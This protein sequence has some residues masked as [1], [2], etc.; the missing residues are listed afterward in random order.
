M[1]AK[2]SV[3]ELEARLSIARD[4]LADTRLF[5]P[6]SGVVTSRIPDPHEMVAQGSPVMTLDD[7]SRIEI[8]VDVPETHIGRFL[9]APKAE[10]HYSA[11]F[12]TRKDKVFNAVL[13]EYSSRADQA[14]GTYRFVFTVTPAP[15]DL[16]FAGM[17][18]QVRLSA[19]SEKSNDG[20]PVV[21]V[22]LESLLGVAGNSAHVFIVDPKSGTLSRRAVTFETLA[23]G[24]QVK[25]TDGLLEDDLVVKQG[26]AFVRQGQ[27]VEYRM[28]QEK[29]QV[30]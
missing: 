28:I 15:E 14:T 18:A 11:V 12:L 29:G 21:A 9:E 13:T 10:G 27:T 25:V 6:F 24:S 3:K 7:L 23:G 26:A 19:A 16:I 4:Q 17:T 8:P 5:A 22:P 1:A 20:N 2:A 30:K